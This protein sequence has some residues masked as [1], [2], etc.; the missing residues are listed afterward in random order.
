MSEIKQ[1]LYHSRRSS[2][3]AISLDD[4]GLHGDD[5]TELKLKDLVVFLAESIY[6]KKKKTFDEEVAYKTNEKDLPRVITFP[7]SRHSSYFELCH[8]V[9]VFNPMDVY[10]CTVD[11][12]NWH[13]GRVTLF[14]IPFLTVV[15]VQLAKYFDNC[16]PPESFSR[17]IY[18]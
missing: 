15:Q 4:M 17:I 18:R 6:K 3:N 7:Y 8:L 13:E 11:E 10:P 5:Q 16:H 14:G 9:R 1:M 2:R 12:K